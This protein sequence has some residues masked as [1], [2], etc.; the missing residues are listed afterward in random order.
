MIA[1]ITCL[2]PGRDNAI[3]REIVRS[4]PTIATE[5]LAKDK[6]AANQLSESH[7]VEIRARAEGLCPDERR[8]QNNR[9]ERA[10]E[11]HGALGTPHP[12]RRV[13]L[14]VPEWKEDAPRRDGTAV[15]VLYLD[16]DPV[17]QIHPADEIG[18]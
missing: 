11:H 5:C 13:V 2:H 17:W 8:R 3:L 18:M 12:G 10:P 14:V 4:M 6:G 1:H 16:V 15:A 9:H 7:K